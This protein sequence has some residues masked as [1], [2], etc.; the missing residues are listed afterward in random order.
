MMGTGVGSNSSSAGSRIADRDI[1]Y[2]GGY[3]GYYTES[4]TVNHSV[5]ESTTSPCRFKKE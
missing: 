3:P 2:V 1:F 5:M 4:L